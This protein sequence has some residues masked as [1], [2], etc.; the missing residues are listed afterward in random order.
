MKITRIYLK[1][2]NSLR[3]E[4][5]INL[6]QEPFASGG[7][8]AITGPTGAG[9]STILDAITLAL[10]GRAARY[11]NKPNPENMMS[12]GTGECHAEVE[13]EVSKGRYRASW[14]MKRSRGK[15]E[16]KIQP[17][18]RFVYDAEGTVLAQNVSEA[19]R[20]VEELTG[21]DVD[22]FFRSVLLAQ[23]D[24]VKFLK[25]TSD[26]RSSLL[27][28]LTGMDIYSEISI[29]AHE[30]TSARENAL[31]LR[32]KDLE[33]IQL[34]DAENMQ[35]LVNQA[36]A[37]KMEIKS[38]AINLAKLS[39]LIA[40]GSNLVKYLNHEITLHKQLEAIEGE[41]LALE[42]DTRRLQLFREGS[43]F[44][45]GLQALDQS[46]KVCREKKREADEAERDVL[47]VSRELCAGIKATS[48]IISNDISKAEKKI[49]EAHTS[50]SEKAKKCESLHEWLQIHHH[51]ETLDA[52]LSHIVEHVTILIYHREKV[53]EVT[54][55][56]EALNKDLCAE[57]GRFQSLLTEKDKASALLDNSK[58]S[59]EA[60]RNEY[61][62]LLQGKSFD[63]IQQEVAELERLLN[64]LT[65]KAA[66]LEALESY[67]AEI[68]TLDSAI[69]E[70]I[71]ANAEALKRTASGESSL[72]EEEEKISALR[73]M[74]EH[75]RLITS[76]HE[77][78]ENL[79][80]GAPCPL[81]GSL[82]H[83]YAL[84]VENSLFRVTDVE[85]ELA[86]LLENAPKK[87][88][89]LK[90]LISECARIE[91]ALR[92]NT[93]NRGK[94]SLK[95]EKSRASLHALI[96]EYEIAD[97]G[98]GAAICDS[99]SVQEE[100]NSRE[101]ELLQ[102][103]A[104]LK[105]VQE[106]GMREN[107]SQKLLEKS[108]YALEIAENKIATQKERIQ[109]L[110]EQIRAC[111][112]ALHAA[113]ATTSQLEITII[114]YLEAY[115]EA[116]PPPGEEKKL[117][118]GLEKRKASYQ[119]ALKLSFNL[120]N[121][122]VSLDLES[123][124]LE[125][126][127]EKLKLQKSQLQQLS[128]A[129]EIHSFD[130]DPKKAIEF[131]AL[132][133]TPE[134][135]LERLE[136]LKTALIIAQNSRDKHTI[137]LSKAQQGYSE[138]ER[139]LTEELSITQFA[140]IEELRGAQLPSNDVQR[141][142]RCE[143]DIKSRFDRC[144]GQLL[145]VRIE[146]ANLTSKDIPQGDQLQEISQQ[147]REMEKQINSM[148]GL[149][150]VLERRLLE[151]K[152]NHLLYADLLQEIEGDRKRLS[153]WQKLASLI[154][155]HDGKSFRKFAQGLSLDLLIRHANIHLSSLNNRYR[156][157]RA[158]GNE[159]ELEIQD[160]HQ[161]NAIR[162][163]ASLSGGESFLA[164]LAL[165]LGLSDL[166][167]KN[168]RIDSLFIDE[169]FGSL[170][171]ET[172]ETAVQALESLRTK[173]KTIGVISHIELLKERISTQIALE[174]GPGGISTMTIL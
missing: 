71:N 169:G 41:K 6:D 159:L 38:N 131:A 60:S 137:E 79:S 34:L 121:T 110:G 47:K 152:E 133:K 126:H 102:R 109:A 100:K 155:S 170:D 113:H 18:S 84:T 75:K 163:T 62:K 111:E 81:C 5:T 103:R 68:Q 145:Q 122:L 151:D 50:R 59:L 160:L 136:E 46:L 93:E 99:S 43:P 140:T 78:R 51:D 72:R 120:S 108:Q 3:G 156:L 138:L 44:F 91:E 174:K 157:K 53:R 128:E 168:V 48:E 105:Q 153:I 95:A 15:A 87:D 66:S 58:M 8:F 97:K 130:S 42:A 88:R 2:L 150:A 132:Y 112:G 123:E 90:K 172:L 147:Q 116:V 167:G 141:I 69:H 89:E 135:A 64:F 149:L 61:S 10:Y 107:E 114:P 104:L 143:E 77:H 9:K 129:Y 13:F 80:P 23:G 134:E 118:E 164:S 33:N 4:F 148:H 19:N 166:A 54:R 39:D 125:Q 45:P 83:P 21:L 32:E 63:Q 94:I 1:N 124:K 144:H 67:A 127:C 37:Y 101:E 161:T 98:A 52:N 16:G 30:E 11:D 55:Q 171:Y 17:V 35:V 12:R 29:K 31:K 26:E 158:P 7:I 14:Q 40:Q 106:S 74:R 24:F 22:R 165:A 49:L 115:G 76:L 25:A 85:K 162:P 70:L 173:N 92:Y 27:E 28:K 65:K 82:D 154:G 142:Q 56:L 117:L 36:L 119:D 146:L 73:A 57:E 96:R 20:I 86:S 139:R